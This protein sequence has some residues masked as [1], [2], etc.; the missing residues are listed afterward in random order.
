[1]QMFCDLNDLNS[2]TEPEIR[3]A[4]DTMIAAYVRGT[5]RLDYDWKDQSF[6][7]HKLFERNTKSLKSQYT[8]LTFKQMKQDDLLAKVIAIVLG[9]ADE[10]G[11]TKNT[12]KA[13]YLNPD[14]LR[15]FSEGPKIKK[16]LDKLYYML[17][18]KKYKKGLNAGIFLNIV[19]ITNYLINEKSIRV[20]HWG[21]VCDWYFETQEKLFAVSDEE[22]ALGIEESAFS[23]KTRL[24][25]DANGMHMRL[26]WLINE[27]DSCD[28]I[29]GVDPKRVVS[30]KELFTVWM[31]QDDGKGNKVCTDCE[32]K[33][34]FDKAIKGHIIPHSAGGSTDIENT[35]AICEECN[36]IEVK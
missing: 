19:I 4:I 6:P 18:D 31:S 15:T 3:N 1:M 17:E 9:V 20:N 12:L 36:R 35:K 5:A 11:I 34:R 7:I 30:D 14:Y 16:V 28:G 24:G 22:K 2:M 13:M 27:L 10:K 21:K 26:Y 33:L 29:V 32:T 23:Q 25:M 8:N